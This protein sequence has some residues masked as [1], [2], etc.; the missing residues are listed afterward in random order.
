MIM[1]ETQTLSTGYLSKKCQSL[2]VIV[3]PFVQAD[4]QRRDDTNIHAWGYVDGVCLLPSK[5]LSCIEA[6]PINLRHCL[7]GRGVNDVAVGPE[8]VAIHEE[9]GRLASAGV[10]EVCGGFGGAE[11]EFALHGQELLALRVLQEVARG[12]G[13][14]LLADREEWVTAQVGDVFATAERHYTSL[15]T[16]DLLAF[17]C[18]DIEGVAGKR[19]D[20]FSHNDGLRLPGIELREDADRLRH[21]HEL[22]RL[23]HGECLYGK[24]RRATAALRDTMWSKSRERC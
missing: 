6:L 20:L 23:G 10:C 22:D 5:Q 13:E 2:I 12:N 15:D 16:H 3:L 1:V 4:A 19:E 24:T 9:L 7:A 18:L 21:R 17:E 8:E 11:G 14:E